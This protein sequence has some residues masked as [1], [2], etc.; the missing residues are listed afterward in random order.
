MSKKRR[1]FEID[2]D[3]PLE[4]DVPAGTS[5][6]TVPRRGPMAAA[7]SE[8]ADALK[9][10][11]DAETAIRAENDALAQEHVRL[12]KLGL[13]T[14]LIPLDL[15]DADKLTRDR[16][17]GRDPEIDELKQSITDVGLSNPIRVER[18]GERFE[19][20]QGFRRLSAFRELAAEQGAPYDR[21]PAVLNAGGDDL[22]LLY[23]R[24]VDENLVRRGVSFGELAALAIAYSRE[25]PNITNY[26]E[27]VEVIFASASRQKRS[28]IRSFVDLLGFIG[29]DLRFPEGV[30]RA[31]GHELLRK[32]RTAGA[33]GLSAALAAAPDRDEEQEQH[34]LRGW[35]AA[36]PAQAPKE[37]TAKTSLRINRPEGV[38]KCI[39][40]PGRIDL[41]LD[42]DFSTI[43][44]A[45]LERALAQFFDVLDG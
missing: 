24:M 38:A 22:K 25:D 34:I 7:I 21:I 11:K 9:S 4:S 5:D 44:R 10:R 1:V 37:T 6:A 39:A 36:K 8:N 41:R 26:H 32:L 17:P 35:L 19:L 33:G 28:H 13:I 40:A 14:D 27:A 18:A 2:F 45:K 31:M 3:E 20:V 29:D 42:R 43:D 16:A 30:P 15:I 23:R 12:K